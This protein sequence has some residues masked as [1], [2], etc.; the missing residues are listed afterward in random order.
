M[1]AIDYK[2]FNWDAPKN[3]TAVETKA[4]DLVVSGMAAVWAGLDRQQENFVRGAFRDS[5]RE[6]LAQPSG[7]PLCF[8]HQKAKAIGQ[9]IDLRETDEGLAFKALV[10][11]QEPSSPLYYIYDG[12]RRGVYKGV[13]VAGIFKR[14]LME[15]GFRIAKADLV[16]ISITPAPVHPLTYAMAEE[17]KAMQDFCSAGGRSL[18][19]VAAELAQLENRMTLWAARSELAKLERLRG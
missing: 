9:V 14:R 11:K 2:S 4:G 13:S 17:V 16:E 8:H 19:D 1:E 5:I 15:G 12:I 18:D 7:A 10:T 3:V 6:F